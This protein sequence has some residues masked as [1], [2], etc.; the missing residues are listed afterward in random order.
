MYLPLIGRGLL[1]DLEL[2]A[3]GSELLRERSDL[4]LNLLRRRLQ[5]PLQLTRAEHSLVQL[6]LELGDVLGQ[7]GN[8]RL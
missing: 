1:Q 6:R 5:A 4:L 2:R 7:A 8:F 3:T